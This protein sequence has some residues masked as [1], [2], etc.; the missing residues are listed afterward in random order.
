MPAPL[1]ILISSCF[2]AL[3]M[4]VVLLIIAKTFPKNIQGLREWALSVLV[5]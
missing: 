5:I 3:S 2:M 4:S 1:I